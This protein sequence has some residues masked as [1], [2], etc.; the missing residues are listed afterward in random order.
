M[1]HMSEDQL[2]DGL[3]VGVKRT[4]A[5]VA[6][7]TD[8]HG[9]P[10]ETEYLLT[11]D[12]AQAFL[13]V[14]REVSVE[15]QTQTIYSAL[16]TS[17]LKTARD[18]VGQQRIDVVVGDRLFPNALIEIKIRIT[19][20]AG[21]CGDLDK[22]V[23]TLTPLNAKALRSIEGVSLFQLH[24]DHAAGRTTPEDFVEPLDVL[25]RRFTTDLATF[26]EAWPEFT[27]AFRPLHMSPN[28][29]IV[30]QSIDEDVDG[31]PILGQPAYATRYYAVL[32]RH[33]TFGTTASGGF[34][35]LKAEQKL[36]DKG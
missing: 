9:G 27:F 28:E 10:A 2:L 7:L 23:K 25:E 15:R 17:S 20:V 36:H 14:G 35:Q 31:S 3:R 33:K 11:Y 4:G 29:G 6:A 13:D 21:I 18:L 16:T 1:N 26:A 12:V 32:V 30:A 5:F 24:L 19:T 34:A 22:L 8:Y